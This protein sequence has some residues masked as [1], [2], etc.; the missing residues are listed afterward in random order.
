MWVVR[1]ESDAWRRGTTI[2]D[3]EAKHLRFLPLA[4]VNEKTFVVINQ[5]SVAAGR[6]DE[7]VQMWWEI[8]KRWPEQ[9]I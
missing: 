6:T 7:T 1:N 5:S 4:R 3:L 8:M 9:E 2:Q